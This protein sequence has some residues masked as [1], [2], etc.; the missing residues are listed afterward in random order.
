MSCHVVSCVWS[1]N[2]YSDNGVKIT[3]DTRRGIQLWKCRWL[4]TTRYDPYDGRVVQEC[5]K[6]EKKGLLG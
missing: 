6:L 2:V 1:Q 5:Q 3:K 4:K